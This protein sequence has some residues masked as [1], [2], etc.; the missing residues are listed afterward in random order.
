MPKKIAPDKEAVE[1]RGEAP[2]VLVG[3][4][5]ALRGELFL[6]NPGEAR[7]VFRGAAIRSGAAAPM[8]AAP[9]PGGMAFPRA[10]EE[11]LVAR[12]VPA[13]IVKPGERRRVPLRFTLDPTTPPGEYHASLQM[14]DQTWP[15]IFHVT[16]HVDLDISP[17]ELVIH[18]QPGA[19]VTKEIVIRNLSNVELTIDETSAVPLDDELAQCRI[20]RAVAAAIG[21]QKES[22]LDDILTEFAH[23]SKSVLDA[24]GILR[25][26]NRSGRLT[27][28]PSEVR[29]IELEIRL[30]DSLEKR[31]RY[32]A[33]L[34]IYNADLTISIVPALDVQSPDKP[35]VN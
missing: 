18:N 9:P 11:M 26:R 17:G 12:K 24:A 27:L 5:G 8:K 22:D 34:P 33:V 10:V 14:A 6:H 19:T 20:L 35:R 23:Q 31:T 32:R 16:E 7:M 1:V 15:V 2:I 21:S 30:P 25:V 3:Q 13:V 4:P 29:R 28:Q